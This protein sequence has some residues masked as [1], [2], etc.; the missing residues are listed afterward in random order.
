[1]YKNRTTDFDVTTVR[2]ADPGLAVDD[3][4]VGLMSSDVGLTC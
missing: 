4:E 3:D 1:M 2:H